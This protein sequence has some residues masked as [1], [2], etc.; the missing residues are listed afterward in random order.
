MRRYFRGLTA[1]TIVLSL[2]YITLRG[3]T[4]VVYQM[5]IDW[6]D[7]VLVLLT[8]HVTVFDPLRTWIVTRATRTKLSLSYQASQFVHTLGIE[9]QQDAQQV[10]D[11]LTRLCQEHG[12]VCDHCWE[13]TIVAV[14]EELRVEVEGMARESWLTFTPLEARGIAYPLAD[15]CTGLRDL[16]GVLVGHGGLARARVYLRTCADRVEDLWKELGPEHVLVDISPATDLALAIELFTRH[17]LYLDKKPIQSP[18]MIWNQG[19]SRAYGVSDV[20]RDVVHCRLL[21]IHPHALR[22][23]VGR[24]KALALL[25]LRGYLQAGII[26]EQILHEITDR[27]Q[28][29]EGLEPDQWGELIARWRDF[30]CPV[31]LQWFKRFDTDEAYRAYL[32]KERLDREEAQRVAAAK[33]RQERELREAL[34]ALNAPTLIKRGQKRWVPKAPDEFD[35][36]LVMSLLEIPEGL[37]SLN[38]RIVGAIVVVG[39]M[40]EGERIPAWK[41]RPSRQNRKI[42]TQIKGFIGEIQ[43]PK[44]EMDDTIKALVRAKVI[45]QSGKEYRLRNLTETLRERHAPAHALLSSTKGLRAKAKAAQQHAQRNHDQQ[46]SLP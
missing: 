12:Q 15:L 16:Q 25:Q 44:R 30:G 14:D 39:L 35:H 26:D 46:V 3:Y 9:N 13:E 23:F 17:E 20:Y 5:P 8:A 42:W 41:D 34:E 27:Q 22:R 43:H 36:E 1:A 18:W 21:K 32:E 10:F 2:V 6:F 40:F 28:T 37:S 19:T 7:Y 29:L 11:L 24:N 4:L 33:A 38:P 31:N 45:D